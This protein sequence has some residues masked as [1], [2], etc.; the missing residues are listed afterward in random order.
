MIILGKKNNQSYPV[1]FNAFSICLAFYTAN[2]IQVEPI[3][4][5][6]LSNRS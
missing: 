6:L 3:Y 2:S 5:A 1:K 4:R